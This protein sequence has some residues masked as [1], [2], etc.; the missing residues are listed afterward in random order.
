MKGNIKGK[1]NTLDELKRVRRR[2]AESELLEKRHKKIEKELRESEKKYQTRA[3][4]ISLGVYRN[5]GGPNGRFL[6]ANPAI[7]KMF[8]YDSVKEFMRL[9]IIPINSQI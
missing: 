9:S 3:E 6:Q 7:G 1:E 2:I 4:S 8:G 5:T